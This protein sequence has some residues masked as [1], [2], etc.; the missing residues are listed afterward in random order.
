MQTVTDIEDAILATLEAD[1]TLAGYVKSFAAV[2]SLDQAAL[3][4]TFRKL[5]AI[6]VI[7]EEGVYDYALGYSQSDY[8]TFAILCFAKNMRSPVAAMRG[9]IAAETGVWDMIDDCRRV[10]LAGTLTGVTV[11]DCLA[12]R[13]KLIYAGER[14]AVA[15]LEIEVQWRS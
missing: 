2:P 8:G 1:E 10:V 12:K 7:S 6:G 15:A 9:G 11:I 5:P 3:E 14:G 13:R 4:K